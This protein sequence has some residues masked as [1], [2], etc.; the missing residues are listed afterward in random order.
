MNAV[1]IGKKI[2]GLNERQVTCPSIEK[3]R[4]PFAMVF[5]SRLATPPR[6]ARPPLSPRT[7]SVQAIV[8]NVESKCILG[9]LQFRAGKFSSNGKCGNFCLNL[10]EIVG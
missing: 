10:Y 3:A 9:F 1:L 6:G 2:L 5:P 4:P 7:R 8:S